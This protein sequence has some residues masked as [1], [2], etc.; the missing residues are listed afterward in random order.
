MAVIRGQST[1]SSSWSGF[2]AVVGSQSTNWQ[3]KLDGGFMAAVRGQSTN[4]QLKLEW[5]H[6]SCR[7]SEH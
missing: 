4:W 6:G 1:G 7:E 5:I 2:M 3:L